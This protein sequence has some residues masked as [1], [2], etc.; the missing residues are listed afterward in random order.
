MGFKI[1][2]SQR[3]QQEIEHALEFYH[4]RNPE[5]PKA[6]F[7]SLSKAYK[8]LSIN[9]FFKIDYKNIRSL[10]IQ[11]FPFSLFFTVNEN[12]QLVTI[13]SCFHTSREPQ[14]RP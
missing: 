6:F 14:K 11:R 4:T 13:L 1:I 9:P 2:I 7:Q 3:A 5:L 10:K 8:T 12:Q